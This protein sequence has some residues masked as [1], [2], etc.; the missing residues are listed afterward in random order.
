MWG[1]AADRVDFMEQTP[2]VT[3]RFH[4]R[5]LFTLSLLGVADAG[6]CWWAYESVAAR[7]PSMQLFFG[8]E[9]GSRSICVC[10]TSPLP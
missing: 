5:M 1:G 7:G 10:I 9:V 3:W 4:V 8:F 2:H 6:L